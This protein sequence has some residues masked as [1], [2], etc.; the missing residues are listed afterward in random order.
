MVGTEHTTPPTPDAVPDDPRLRKGDSRPGARVAPAL[1]GFI[2][3][4]VCIVVFIGGMQRQADEGT[5]QDAEPVAA[6]PRVVQEQETTWADGAVP[7]RIN[8]DLAYDEA[9]YDVTGTT[10]GE[11]FTSMDRN[12]PSTAKGKAAGLTRMEGRSY[13]YVRDPATDICYI[14][15]VHGLITVTLPDLQNGW[16]MP[17]QIV[18]SWTEYERSVAHHEQQHVAIYRAGAERAVKQLERLQPFP[19]Q[20]AMERGFSEV[21]KAEM[22]AA[23]SEN[24]AFHRR[25][26]EDT[27]M[28]RE[29]MTNELARVERELDE[30]ASRVEEYERAHPD[31]RMPAGDLRRYNEAGQRLLVLQTERL[32]LAENLAW[33]R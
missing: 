25:E 27:R 3:A 15:H 31:L 16:T 26:V 14:T 28:E 13:D 20:A 4:S 33:L 1:A 8:L 6:Q 19:D 24:E 7:T 18:E 30:A 2:V 17:E 32:R 23:D 5:S 12:A 29:I 9:Y 22:D 21:W 10:P 11:I